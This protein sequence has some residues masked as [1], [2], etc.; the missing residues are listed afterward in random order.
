MGK[1]I[2]LILML[3]ALWAGAQI[4]SSGMSGAVSQPL[5]PRER[6]L[7]AAASDGA[8][9]APITERVRSRV[10]ADLEAGFARH[11]GSDD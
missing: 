9:R 4:Y 8:P 10:S 3:C 2:G 6:E 1:T 11:T 7:G 5:P